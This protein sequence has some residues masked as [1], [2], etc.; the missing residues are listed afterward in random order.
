MSCRHA[1]RIA[2]PRRLVRE[3]EER[4]MA[5][6]AQAESEEKAA[7]RAERLEEHQRIFGK[8]PFATLLTWSWVSDMAMCA[9]EQ[10]VKEEERF[11][12]IKVCAGVCKFTFRLHDAVR[13]PQ[14]R[15]EQSSMQAKERLAKI[16][17][18]NLDKQRQETTKVVEEQKAKLD[19]QRQERAAIKYVA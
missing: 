5:A 2:L 7:K 9:G 19:V 15:K 17:Q 8:Q 1:N 4:R 11:A 12:A 18:R 6:I 10:R 16:K 3:A 14:Q 13:L